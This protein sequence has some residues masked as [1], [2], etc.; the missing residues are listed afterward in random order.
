[1]CCGESYMNKM[2]V[3]AVYDNGGETADRYTVVFDSHD[4]RPPYYDCLGM[5]NNPTNPLGF[6]QWGTCVLGN[7][8][9]TEINFSELP[10]HIQQHVKDRLDVNKVEII[11]VDR[12]S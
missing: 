8:M 6:S 4:Q 10:E 11:L 7:H 12:L 5:S 1:M 3:K 9:G 2:K